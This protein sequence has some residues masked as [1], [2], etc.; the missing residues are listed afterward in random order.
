MYLPTPEELRESFEASRAF[1]PAYHL[2]GEEKQM[3]AEWVGRILE[4]A[5]DLEEGRNLKGKRLRSCDVQSYASEIQGRADCIL[6][7]LNVL[8]PAN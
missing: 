6:D 8:K 7:F 3:L 1:M 5:D 4:L 2:R